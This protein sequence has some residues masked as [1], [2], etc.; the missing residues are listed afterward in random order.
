M[1][2]DRIDGHHFRVGPVVQVVH[3]QYDGDEEDQQHGQRTH[4]GFEQTLDDE[5]PSSADEV[6]EHDECHAHQGYARADHVAHQVGLVETGHVVHGKGVEQPAQHQDD[7]DGQRPGLN[8]AYLIEQG[9]GDCCH[10]S[11][12]TICCMRC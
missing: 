4:G 5:A 10:S 7:A 3:A 6:V 11:T 2:Q 12:S 9:A 1:L 8:T